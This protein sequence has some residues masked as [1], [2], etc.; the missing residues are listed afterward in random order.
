MMIGY[1]KTKIIELRV[2]KELSC[3]YNEEMG[4]L[5]MMDCPYGFEEKRTECQTCTRHKERIIETKVIGER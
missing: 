4:E 3:Y 1:I 2:V 5:Y